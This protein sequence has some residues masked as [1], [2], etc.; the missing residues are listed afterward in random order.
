[1]C[2]QKEGWTVFRITDGRGF[3]PV[4]FAKERDAKTY[5]GNIEGKR[6]IVVECKV[7]PPTMP[8]HRK[9]KL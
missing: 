7:M 4:S 8:R 9:G 3:L 2:A 5:A 1:M 6:Y